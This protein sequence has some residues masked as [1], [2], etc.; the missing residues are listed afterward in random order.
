MA[1]AAGWAPGRVHHDIKD[2]LAAAHGS[3]ELLQA[4]HGK[5][6]PQDARELVELALGSIAGGIALLQEASRRQEAAVPPARQVVQ[7]AAML[8]R[9]LRDLLAVD[10]M[11]K[12]RVEVRL[13]V[14]EVVCDEAAL[15][16]IIQ[17]L[18]SNALRHGRPAAP[19]RVVAEP[20]PGGVHLSVQNEG[21]PIP[22]RERWHVFFNPGHQG[23]RNALDLTHGMDGRLW[24]EC[25]SDDEMTVSVALPGACP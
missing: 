10:P 11:A 14:G 4:R 20:E 16:R 23:L 18:V 8:D 19:V 22:L 9:V 21:A 25:P 24:L 17:N 3:L 15:R 13:D 7:L 5:D 6:L 2:T 12:A 1:G